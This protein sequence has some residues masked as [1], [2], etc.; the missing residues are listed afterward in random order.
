M[1]DDRTGD[2][3]HTVGLDH[4]VVLTTIS[5]V[6]VVVVLILLGGIRRLSGLIPTLNVVH[7]QPKLLES[8]LQD[9]ILPKRLQ[10]NKRVGSKLVGTEKAITLWA[11]L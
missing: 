5:S 4:T 7:R 10:R 8:A 6:L 9:Q 1:D 3:S 2:P 11:P